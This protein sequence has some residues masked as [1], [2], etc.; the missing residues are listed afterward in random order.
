MDG[1]FSRVV[2]GA[3][4]IGKGDEEESATSDRARV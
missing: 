2:R 1:R 4:E 3:A